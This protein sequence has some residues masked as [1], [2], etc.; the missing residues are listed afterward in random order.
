VIVI[1]GHGSVDDAAYE[2]WV[3]WPNGPIRRDLTRRAVAVQASM[4]RGC[5]RHTGR[6]VSTIRKHDDMTGYNPSVQVICGIEGLTP[7]LGYILSG[8]PP[9]LIR[10]LHGR[11]LRFTVGGT[12]VFATLVR[13]PGTAPNNF[14]LAAL[15]AAG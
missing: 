9:H 10:P 3:R 2:E 14:V 11:A 12:I 7:Y 6:L 1:S 8:T 4:T 15:S 13:H 5:P